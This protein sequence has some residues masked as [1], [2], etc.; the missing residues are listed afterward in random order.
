MR[1]AFIMILDHP[2]KCIWDA[3]IKTRISIGHFSLKLNI[4][5]QCIG[6]PCGHTGHVPGISHI[7]AHLEND[8]IMKS[9]LPRYI[10]QGESSELQSK[11][12]NQQSIIERN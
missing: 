5:I 10:A 3:G 7:C 1:L 11:T 2:S 4:E 6:Y 8:E 12:N 9:I